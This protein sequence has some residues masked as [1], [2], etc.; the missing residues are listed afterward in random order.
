MWK[1]V[2][3]W[4]RATRKSQEVRPRAPLL[5]ERLEPRTLLS[6]SVVN[7]VPSIP[8]TPEEYA[9][10]PA[11]WIEPVAPTPEQTSIFIETEGTQ[12]RAKIVFVFPERGYYVP[13][14]G[15]VEQQGN[16]FLVNPQV[17]HWT[18]LAHLEYPPITHEYDLGVLP[19]GD[20]SVTLQG[21]GQPIEQREFRPGDQQWVPYVPTLEQTP[22]SLTVDET[23]T[24]LHVTMTFPDDGYAVRSWG[25]VQQQGTCLRV[26]AEVEH[27]TGPAE[28]AVT[29]FSHEYDLT[30]LPVESYTFWMYVQ[31]QTVRGYTFTQTGDLHPVYRF[32]SPKLSR[33]FYTIRAAER[34]K[35]ISN[36]AHVWTYEGPAYSAYPTNSQPD[37]VPVYRFWSAG[38]ET[39]FYTIREAEKTKLM[40]NYAATW[41][42][43]GVAFYVY[44]QYQG[45]VA[46]MAVYRFWSSSLSGHFF[47]LAPAEI[48]KL[49]LLPSY[50]WDREC[51]AWY[52]SA[53]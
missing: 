24:R 48:D 41:T 6:V 52:A 49:L 42:Y 30:A 28:Q 25:V 9:G 26:D 8:V 5:F 38:L 16:A 31:D 4:W 17:V 29:S 43:E 7:V 34:D 45:I 13:D 1:S 53:V 12:T 50:I 3:G 46:P 33:H 47:T 15:T 21:Q 10:V 51:T 37:T 11:E 20:Y 19:E 32:W 36:Y 27:W 23:G 39:H 35:L 2:W 40:E 14:W 44:P 22:M 18:D